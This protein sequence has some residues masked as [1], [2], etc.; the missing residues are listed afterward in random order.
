MTQWTVTTQQDN[1]GKYF[2]KHEPVTGIGATH[3]ADTAW[4]TEAEALAAGRE[5]LQRHHEALAAPFAGT[6]MEHD[7]VPAK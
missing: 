4:D 1:L 5:A 6:S 2:W 7:A 3:I